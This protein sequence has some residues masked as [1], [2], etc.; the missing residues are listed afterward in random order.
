M[1]L[2]HIQLARA[3]GGRRSLAPDGL[4]LL[5][6]RGVAGGAMRP[7]VVVARCVGV[8]IVRMLLDQVEQLA[9]L[10]LADLQ[11]CNFVCRPA[12]EAE[13]TIRQKPPSDKNGGN[14]DNNVKGDES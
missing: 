5:C 11:L 12:S 2:V 3:F 6:L 14:D 1:L 9:I 10:E 7:L 13:S 4:T 8:R